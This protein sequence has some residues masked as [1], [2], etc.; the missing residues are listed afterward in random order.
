MSG[1]VLTCQG[2]CGAQVETAVSKVIA[3]ETKT[4]IKESCKPMKRTGSRRTTE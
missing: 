1:P 2:L 4:V 3:E